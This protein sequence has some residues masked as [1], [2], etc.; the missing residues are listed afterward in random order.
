MTESRPR[1]ATSRD[2]NQARIVDELRELGFYVRDVSA[3]IAEFDILVY[4]YHC[5]LERAVWHC[6]EIKTSRGQ[7][8]PSQRDFLLRHGPG[9]VMVI[10][11]TEDVLRFYE[12]TGNEIG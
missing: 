7:L 6:F 1:Y 4:G 5:E 11:C 9:I 10:Q 2:S 3:H 8:Q 12:R